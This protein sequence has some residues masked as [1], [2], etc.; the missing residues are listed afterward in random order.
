MGLSREGLG[1][2]TMPLNSSCPFLALK[3]IRSDTEMSIYLTYGLIR[4]QCSVLPVPGAGHGAGGG[5]GGGG[6][7]SSLP[8]Q[9]PQWGC[10]VP[11]VD[12]FLRGKEQLPCADHRDGGR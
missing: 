7:C 2:S 9:C 8:G 4:R 3:I 10:L 12:P 11:R 1:I 5:G 6:S